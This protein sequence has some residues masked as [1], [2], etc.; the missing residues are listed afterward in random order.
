MKRLTNST[1]TIQFID[2]AIHPVVLNNAQV[3]LKTFSLYNLLKALIRTGITNQQYFVYSQKK[4][5]GQRI[6]TLNI[7]EMYNYT[8]AFESI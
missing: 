3:H 8:T 6:L 5:N 4:E 7:K 1:N 2:F